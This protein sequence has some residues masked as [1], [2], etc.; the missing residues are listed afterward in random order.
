MK[1]NDAWTIDESKRQDRLV[2][3]EI[4]ESKWSPWRSFVVVVLA[5]G[6]ALY[7]GS[8]ELNELGIA[9][10]AAP[11]AVYATSQITRVFS[12]SS[13]SGQKAE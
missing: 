13:R 12:A 8:L 10:I 6:A 7:C 4:R 3:A 11:V 9:F 1:W 2:E 5:M